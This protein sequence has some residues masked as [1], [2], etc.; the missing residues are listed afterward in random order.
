MN[1]AAKQR[2]R[3][4]PTFPEDRQ[5]SGCKRELVRVLAEVAVTLAPSP[6]STAR[7]SVVFARSNVALPPISAP[8]VLSRSDPPRINAN[9][10]ADR[11]HTLIILIG[12]RTTV[13]LFR[14]SA[15][16]GQ[17]K[18][19]SLFVNRLKGSAAGWSQRRRITLRSFCE[20]ASQPLAD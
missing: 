13:F 17:Q 8:P 6:S 18:Q 9:I 14:P 12:Q 15:R 16:E 5:P 4:G 11:L 19:P 1:S 3:S 10:P 2:T 7:T 20:E